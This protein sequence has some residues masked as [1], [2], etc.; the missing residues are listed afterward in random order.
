MLHCLSWFVYV[1]AL[2]FAV[3]TTEITTRTEFHLTQWVSLLWNYDSLT[4]C[5]Q[6]VSSLIIIKANK[7]VSTTKKFTWYSYLWRK[8]YKF[9][10]LASVRLLF[11]VSSTDC[12]V[13]LSKKKTTMTNWTCCELYQLKTAEV[14]NFVAPTNVGSETKSSWLDPNKHGECDSFFLGRLRDETETSLVKK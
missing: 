13:F 11:C 10:G 9:G 14:Q 2:H 8:E 4:I 7:I 5:L 3:P 6:A 12:Q 1:F